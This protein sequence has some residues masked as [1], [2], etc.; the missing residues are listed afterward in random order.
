MAYAH[1][2]LEPQLGGTELNSPEKTESVSESSQEGGDAEAHQEEEEDTS[3]LSNEE[4]IDEDEYPEG[5]V[6]LRQVRLLSLA[7]T[8][9][10]SGKLV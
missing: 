10:L 4:V 6:F 5:R 7:A 8:D 9:S 3:Q 1:S 2:K